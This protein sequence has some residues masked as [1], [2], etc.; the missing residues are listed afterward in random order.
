MKAS[1]VAA[2]LCTAAFV[3]VA[4]AGR[5]FAPLSVENGDLMRSALGPGGAHLLGTDELGRDVFSR[6][7]A[8]GREAIAGP[9]VAAIAA[10]LLGTVFG[11]VCGF[12]GGW[13]DNL[14]MRFVDFAYSLPS[15]LIA[16]VVVGVLGGGY[17]VAVMTLIVLAVPG[18]VRIVRAAVLAQRHQ[19]YLEAARVLG[20]SRVRIAVVHVLPNISPTVV[21]NGL[22]TFGYSLVSLSALSFLGLGSPAGS[23]DWG[24]MISE[25]RT[26]L[27][28]NPWASVVPAL[29]LVLVAASVTILG[30]WLLDRRTS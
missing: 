1:V 22:L 28:V 8:G 30:D 21:A 18:D 3:A 4:I 15:G 7:L 27:D 6:I 25:N 29:L 20:L 16:I 2:A 19:P 14:V 26:L 12:L 23:P 9:V 5:W 13:A 17:P 11:L 10:T 24:R